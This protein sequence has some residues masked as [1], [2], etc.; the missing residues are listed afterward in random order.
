[1]FLDH[2]SGSDLCRLMKWNLLFV[3]GR[4]YHAFFFLLH[5]SR[6]FRHHKSYAVNQPDLHRNLF[7]QIDIYRF[8]GN[9]FWFHGCDRFPRTGDRKL[10]P[11]LRRILF[12]HPRKCQKFHEPPDKCRLSRANR[13]YHA[14]KKLSF[15]TGLYIFVDSKWLI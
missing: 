10:I 12:L 7:S 5:I 8:F 4:F 13:S 6:G 15:G 2:F 3:P 1:M 11:H 9:K 14:Q